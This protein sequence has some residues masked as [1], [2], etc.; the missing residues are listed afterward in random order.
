ML[1]NKLTALDEQ[2]AV[3]FKNYTNLKINEMQ[4]DTQGK[5]T[6]IRQESDIK[7]EKTEHK[8]EH[9]FDKLQLLLD[10]RYEEVKTKIEEEIKRRVRDKN[11]Q[12]SDY[13]VMKERFEK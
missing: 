1:I 3:E 10:S 9:S 2:I 12:T 5:L 13:K 7:L 4:I 6:F 8:F 11:E